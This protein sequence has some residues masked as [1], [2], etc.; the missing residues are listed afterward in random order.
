MS[1][2][3][4]VALA[5]QVPLRGMVVGQLIAPGVPAPD[6]R[7]FF[8]AAWNIVDV[9]YFETLRLPMAM[10]RDFNDGDRAATQPVAIITE[11]GARQLWPG[12]DPVGKRIQR[13]ATE[14]GVAGAITT[15]EVIGVARDLKYTIRDGGAP[16]IV[17]YLPFRQRYTPRITVLARMANNQ[18]ATGPIVEAMRTMNAN[19]PL[20]S[21]R[22]LDDP[23]GPVQFQL[24]VAASVAGSVGLVALL[25]AAMGIYGVTA[26]TVARRTRE[27]GIRIAIGAQRG[28]I[29]RLVLGHGI[30][31]VL[32]GCAI[33]L[34]LAIA[35]SRLLTRLLFGSSPLDPVAYGGAVVLFM[36]I[37]LAA[38][39]L[40]VLR[41]IRIDAIETLRYE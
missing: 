27:I 37:G 38:C 24:R 18:H 26:Y 33:G 19:L 5:D 21:A 10:G 8:T 30:S 4:A 11:A 3:E 2:V 17:V 15:L 32:I 22:P 1:G 31:L 12:E 40:P 23:G 36:I 13:K 20:A 16:P 39:Y 14:P 28:D 41:A 9:G 29:V 25:L 34:T 35:A 6:G 7:P